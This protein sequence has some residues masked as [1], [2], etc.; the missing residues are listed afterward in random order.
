[1]SAFYMVGDTIGNRTIELSELVAHVQTL[2]PKLPA[3]L[4]GT[5]RT[6]TGGPLSR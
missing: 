6:A 5:G 3:E 2:V 4:G 1:M